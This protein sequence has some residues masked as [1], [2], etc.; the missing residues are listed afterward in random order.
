MTKPNFFILGA[1][2]CG[3]TSV[4]TWLSQHPEAFV[5]NPKEPR[6]FNSDWKLPFR[7][8][9]EASYERLFESAAGY[10]AIGEATTG[11]LVSDVAV[12]HILKYRPD[13]HFVVCLR[14]PVDLFFSL[15]AQRLK[16]GMESLADPK[17][18][19][20]AQTERIQ[21][22]AIPVGCPEPKL[23]HYDRYCRLGTQMERLLEQIER[24]RL[25]VLFIEDLND[26][27][28]RAYRRLCTFLGLQPYSLPEYRPRNRRSI[29][30]SLLLAQLLRVSGV[31]KRR[32]GLP[33]LGIGERIR[34]LNQRDSRIAVEPRF[35]SLLV[36]HFSDE[37]TRLER[38]LSRDL[39]HWREVRSGPALPYTSPD[40]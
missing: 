6:Y 20:D 29:P 18:A 25:H 11:Y 33:P 14:N 40:E 34:N 39:S 9:D 4:A 35:R 22:K 36:E 12:P 32:V 37:V 7:I 31:L 3:T 19:W 17:S 23:L 24:P 26:N 38:L 21:G 13:A 15:H 1:P 2:K 30:R 28:N 10:S 5:S 16:E 27:A 8:S